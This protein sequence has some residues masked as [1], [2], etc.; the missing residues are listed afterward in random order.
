MVNDRLHSPADDRLYAV[1]DCVAVQ[2]PNGPL[3]L[4]RLAYHAQDQGEVAGINISHDLHGKAL[5]RY[6]PKY[7]PQLISIGRGTGIYTQGDVFKAGAWVDA[8]KKAV[9][10]KHLMSYLTRPLLS[11]ISRKVPG[12]DLFKRLG[13]KLPF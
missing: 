1:G 7:K 12:I 3:L 6:A 13:L 2:G 8:L 5:M 10:R 11:S 4:Q 9:E